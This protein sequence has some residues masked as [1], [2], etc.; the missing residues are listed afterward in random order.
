MGAF[1]DYFLYLVL[2]ARTVDT[3]PL[4]TVWPGNKVNCGYLLMCCSYLFKCS[5]KDRKVRT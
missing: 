5:Y 3:S 1:T 2:H 4:P